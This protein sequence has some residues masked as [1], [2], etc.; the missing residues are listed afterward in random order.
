MFLVM[1]FQELAADDGLEGG[2]AELEVG[3]QHF[4]GRFG[5]EVAEQSSGYAVGPHNQNLLRLVQIRTSDR[6]LIFEWSAKYIGLT[7]M[8]GMR[9]ES[10][11]S[12]TKT[13]FTQSNAKAAPCCFE[14]S[15]RA[16]KKETV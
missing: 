16:T 7:P 3:E 13:S 4:L 2:V 15:P 8:S 1:G 5:G 9:L 12:Q 10:Q 11:K 6:P 14:Q